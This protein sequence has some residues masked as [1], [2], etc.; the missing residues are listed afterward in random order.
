MEVAEAQQRAAE[1]TVLKLQG[2]KGQYDMVL[3]TLETGLENLRA[4]AEALG[5]RMADAEARAARCEEDIRRSEAEA[6]RYRREAE[7]KRSGGAGLQELTASIG[8][9][10]SACKA[11]LAALRAEGEAAGLRLTDL[12]ALSGQMMGDKVG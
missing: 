9:R 3:A 12:Q 10:I 4:E 2:E 5:G 8:Q 11:D 1:D 6:E 7:E